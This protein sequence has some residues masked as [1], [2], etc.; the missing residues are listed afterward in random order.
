M[1]STTRGSVQ[2]LF[3]HYRLLN[4]TKAS[5][6]KLLSL[7]FWCLLWL[8]LLLLLFLFLLFL[9]FFFVLF[10]FLYLFLFLFLLSP[11]TPHFRPHLLTQLKKNVGSSK[12]RKS[13]S[14]SKRL[15]FVLWQTKNFVMA[16]NKLR[17]D[18]CHLRLVISGCGSPN[19]YPNYH[20]T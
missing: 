18:L 1:K 13:L 4:K 15:Q 20:L 9:L 17:L 5:N 12:S 7:S 6:T 16:A 11:I 2:Q 19:N 8:F 3:D 10:L 14:E